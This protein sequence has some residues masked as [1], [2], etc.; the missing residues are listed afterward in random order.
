MSKKS[1]HVL[2][3]GLGVG[4]AV[5]LSLGLASGVLADKPA[6]A[7]SPELPWQD[8]RMLADVL[9]RVKHDYVNPV[10]D[11]QLLQAAIR[12]MVSSLD[13]Y[14]AY[15]DGDEYDEVKISSSGQYS[16]VGIEVSMEDEEVVVVSPFEGSPAA[17]AGIRPGDIIASIDGV[18]V[19]TT[20][21]A[22]TIGRMRG[23]EGTSVRIGIL[24]EG[25]PEPLQFT[26]K[27]SR[28]EL[29]SVKSE[30]LEPGLGYVRISQFSETTGDDLEA[31][32]KD[33]RKRNGTALK[34]LVLD[35]RN[36]PGGVLEA[37]VA[38]SDTFLNS[39]V[40]VTAKGRT[41]E[42]KFEMDATPGD[43]LNGAPIVVLVNGGSAS[44]AEI[45]A[46]ALKD[47]H[48]AT[49]MGRTTFGKGS[50]QTVIPLSGDRA[51][52]LTTSLYY[53]PSGISINH[54]GIAP[55]IELERDPKPPSVAVPEDAPL[56]QRDAEVRRALQELKSPTIGAGKSVSA[57][58]Q[59]R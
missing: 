11:H 22:D 26:L 31:A 3:L 2:L 56:L 29:H 1:R 58:V 12:G 38:V 55:D 42:S 18:P 51:I 41:P 15:L 5:G 47:N 46:G 39:G 48:R 30:L 13:P 4:A 37:A 40:I 19:N 43:A 23:K 50:V 9:E 27:R 20:T 35:L 8:A 32:L 57:A 59:Y 24:R 25:S 14:S 49:L 6:T 52:K 33:L 36:N 53:T 54:R 45:V 7:L 28:V 44:A 10:D 34:G 17:A 16:G 21:L